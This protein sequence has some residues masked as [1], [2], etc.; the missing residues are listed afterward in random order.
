VGILQWAAG[1]QRIGQCQF[2]NYLNLF[3]FIPKS[4]ISTW[5]SGLP[6]NCFPNWAGAAKNP[7]WPKCGNDTN[8]SIRLTG[9][10][11]G[12]RKWIWIWIIF[13]KKMNLAFHTCGFGLFIQI[14]AHLVDKMHAHNGQFARFS[15]KHYLIFLNQF[16]ILFIISTYS[17]SLVVKKIKF[18]SFQ[19]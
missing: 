9:T 18:I 19:N 5:D 4:N 7:D 12:R 10:N 2:T 8:W 14:C 11:L 3:F 16:L 1:F 15:L 17:L 6:S 13:V